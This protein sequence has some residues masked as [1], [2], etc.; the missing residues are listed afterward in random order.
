[1]RRTLTTRVLAVL[2]LATVLP[3][4]VVGGLAIRRAR[5]DLR[6]EV[7]RGNLALIRALGASLDGTLQSARRS[8]DLAAASWADPRTA[9]TVDDESGRRATERLLRRLRREVPLFASISIAGVDG[10]V[11]YGDPIAADLGRSTF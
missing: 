9:T 8:L 5:E 4:L 11:R 10:Q 2:V 3:T 6:R 1:M 7:G